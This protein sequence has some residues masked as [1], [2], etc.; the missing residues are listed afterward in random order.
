LQYPLLIAQLDLANPP[1]FVFGSALNGMVIC[2]VAGSCSVPAS[3]S[4]RHR[5]ATEKQ[6][7][8]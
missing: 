8:G 7:L 1:Y 6:H 2:F 5:A 3:A 4:Q